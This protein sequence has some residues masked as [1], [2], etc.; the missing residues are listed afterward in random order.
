MIIHMPKADPVGAETIETLAIVFDRPVPVPTADSRW[1]VGETQR[2]YHESA[3]RMVEAMEPCVPGGTLEALLAVLLARKAAVLSVADRILTEHAWTLVTV[4]LPPI[5]DRPVFVEI[6][7]GG[8]A[9]SSGYH[10]SG[11]DGWHLQVS[12]R[13]VRRWFL[14]PLP[15]PLPPTEAEQRLAAARVREQAEPIRALLGALWRQSGEWAGLRLEG[16]GH[17]P[18]EEPSA[19]LRRFHRELLEALE[20]LEVSLRGSSS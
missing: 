3:T 8:L 11:P 1:S 4:A 10:G 5:T 19:V 6:D 20:T 12:G 15:E 7:D 16:E 14:P 9:L 13:R 2:A 18:A 17:V